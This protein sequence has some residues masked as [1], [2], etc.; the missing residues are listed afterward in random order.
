MILRLGLATI[1]GKVFDPF[2]SVS[3]IND[4]IVL[5]T[6]LLMR[7]VIIYPYLVQEIVNGPA[8]TTRSEVRTTL[9][10]A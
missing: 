7:A 8:L 3:F 5:V 2:F 1:V 6:F 10:R 4:V 9:F